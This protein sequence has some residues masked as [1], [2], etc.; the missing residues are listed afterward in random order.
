MSLNPNAGN[1]LVHVTGTTTLTSGTITPRFLEGVPTTGSYTVLTSDGGISGPATNITVNIPGRGTDPVPSIQGNSLVFIPLPGGEPLALQWRGNV[2]GAWD[3][4]TTANWVN[5]SNAAD[6]FFDFDSVTFDDSATSFAV[7]IAASTFPRPDAITINNNTDYSFTGAGAIV[8]P[9]GLTKTGTG[10]L[11]MQVNN[12]S[13]ARP[14]SPV[15]WTSAA[16]RADW[17]LDS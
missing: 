16:W 14:A 6:R 3:I 1:D 8:G 5:P 17:A 11:T 7:T 15:P 2:S 13:R 9:T 10:R 12:T 4:E